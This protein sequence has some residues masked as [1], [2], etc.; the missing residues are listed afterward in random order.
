MKRKSNFLIISGNG[1]NTG[2]TSF[3]C[4]LIAS[5]KNSFPVTAIKISPHFH[6]DS[7][8]SDAVISNK[9]Y[10]ILLEK[11]PWRDKDSSRMLSA[12]ADKV[13][14]IEAKDEHLEHA[15]QSLMPMLADDTPVVCE[16]GGMRSLIEPSLFIMLKH[17]AHTEMK[18]GYKKLSPLADRIVSFDGSGFD[19]RGEEIGFDGREWR[20]ERG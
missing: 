19:L 15:L 1:R 17:T 12:G 2:K 3:I 18:E 5:V 11:D 10:S 13:Y 16:S 7:D 4:Q 6:P 9:N 20:F 14:Y 8:T